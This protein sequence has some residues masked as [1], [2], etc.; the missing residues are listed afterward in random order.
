MEERK[1]IKTKPHNVFIEDREKLNI[2]GVRD[3]VSFDEGTIVLNT[4]MGG[5]ILKGTGLHINKLN[6]EDGNLN[7]EGYIIACN[8][9]DKTDSKKSGGL[10]S[11]IFK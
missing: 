11:N 2:T 6:V 10:F 3:V 7:I 1:L 4:E 5:L 9:T 8:Y